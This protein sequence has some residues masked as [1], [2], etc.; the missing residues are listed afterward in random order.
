MRPAICTRCPAALS[1]EYHCQF[2]FVTNDTAVFH[3]P[4]EP[5]AGI[6]NDNGRCSWTRKNAYNPRTL[7]KENASTDRAYTDQR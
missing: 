2:V 6:P 7:T 5:I 3:A 4:S 1:P